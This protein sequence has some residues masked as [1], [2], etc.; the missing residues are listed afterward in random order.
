MDIY[1][2]TES[3]LSF[4]LTVSM[5]QREVELSVA[6]TDTSCSRLN[7]ELRIGLTGKLCK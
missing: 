2:P 7:L 5:T 4:A 6:V 3:N 1:F